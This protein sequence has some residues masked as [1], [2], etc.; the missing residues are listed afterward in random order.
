MSDR[1]SGSPME[2]VIRLDC[3][4]TVDAARFTEA[5][6]AEVKRQPLL[7]ANATVRES[8]RESCWRPATN[9]VPVITWH[10]GDPDKGTG[11]PEDFAP[12]DLEIEIGFRF[13]GWRFPVDDQEHVVM[14]FV[15]HHACCDGKA[16]V[17]FAANTFQRYQSLIDGESDSPIEL[18][19]VDEQQLLNRNLPAANRFG[20]ADRIWRAFVVRPK[21]VGN[22]LLSKPRKIS[23]NVRVAKRDDSD[24]VADPPRQCSTDL[25]VGETKQLAALAR[26]LSASSNTILARE[27][28]HVLNEY[29]ESNSNL[30]NDALR[31]LI[32]FSL[33][34]ERH[35]SMPAANCVSMA[36]LEARQKILKVDGVGDPVLV[37]NL[38]R[39]VDFIRRWNLQYSWIESID[40]YARIWPVIKLL[41]FHRKRRVR[42][43]KQIAST[44]M[45][46]LGQVFRESDLLDSNSE[47]AAGAIVVKSVHLALPCSATVPVAFSLNFYGNRLTIDVTYLPSSIDPGTAESLLD[48]WKQ[49][50]L[51]SVAAMPIDG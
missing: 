38:A 40:L 4:G 9:C 2:F 36:Y 41:K 3:V 25:T 48:S 29:L 16:G 12:I 26:K 14:K 11:F 31:I 17:Q 10:E 47:L 23:G 19:I 45:S 18:P 33:R 30:S 34:D 1:I 6:S 35:H 21:R 49:R 28:F 43:T 32:P 39:Q 44:V 20:F 37:S 51:D 50:I 46:N 13:Y 7:Q 8:H 42:K 15:Y 22:M 5:V 27:L 24:T